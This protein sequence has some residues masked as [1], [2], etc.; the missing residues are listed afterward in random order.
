MASATME[1]Q[2]E[3]VSDFITITD[4]QVDKINA[5]IRYLMCDIAVY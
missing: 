5:T 3:N 2:T 4:L 1:N